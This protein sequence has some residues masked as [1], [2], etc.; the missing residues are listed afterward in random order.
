M[1]LASQTKIDNMFSEPE[2]GSYI[3]TFFSLIYVPDL[4]FVYAHMW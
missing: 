1:S 2:V 4:F 3:F